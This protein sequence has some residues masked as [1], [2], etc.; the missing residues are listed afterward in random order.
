MLED[1]A[2]GED[3]LASGVKLAGDEEEPTKRNEDVA[4]PG[5]GPLY[6]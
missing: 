1:A 6:V 2:E 3:M 4:S 5:P